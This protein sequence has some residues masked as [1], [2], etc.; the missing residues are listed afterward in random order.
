M[1]SKNYAHKDLK[2]DNIMMAGGGHIK[3][4]DFGFAEWFHPDSADG[5]SSPFNATKGTPLY[6]AP[7]VWDPPFGC[8]VDNW[9]A[10]VTLYH[11]LTGSYP[12]CC[13][14]DGT[15]T[16][17]VQELMIAVTQSPAMR[18]PRLSAFPEAEAVVLALLEKN[19]QVR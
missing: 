6:M 8:A 17:G 2:P 12:F 14:V 3:V 16:G 13:T 5:V 18:H 9:A 1:H 7:E 15:L 11:V 4:V 10:G 19:P